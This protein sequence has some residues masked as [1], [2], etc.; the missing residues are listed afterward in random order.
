MN[1]L[2][3]FGNKIEL[4]SHI[5]AKCALKEQKPSNTLKKMEFSYEKIIELLP[6]STSA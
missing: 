5:A 6:M 3:R 1:K 2:I 4:I